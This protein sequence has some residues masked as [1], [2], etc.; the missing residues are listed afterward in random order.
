MSDYELVAI[1]SPEIDEEGM[2]RI[3]DEVGK[4]VTNRGG[5]VNE[6][7]KWGKRKLAYPLRKFKEGNYISTRFKLDS[8][9]IKEVE[10]EI[11]A[12]EEI[13]RHLVVKIGD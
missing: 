6:T 5:A 3:I 1:I 8:K 10:A 7:N 11:R 2:G 12:S 4:R 9:L 13:L